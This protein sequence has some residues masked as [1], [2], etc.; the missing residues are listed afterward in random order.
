[1]STKVHLVSIIENV[2]LLVFYT[3]LDCWQF[4]LISAGGSVF[5]QRR[6]Y[7]T[8]E[9]AEKAGREWIYQGY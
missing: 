7:Y 4:R 3:E 2:T 1:M 9:A 6:I 5:G 8:P